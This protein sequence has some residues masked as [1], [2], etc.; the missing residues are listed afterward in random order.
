[1]Q[2][3][4]PNKK[5]WHS[6]LKTN[7]DR[8]PETQEKCQIKNIQFFFLLYSGAQYFLNTKFG[9]SNE[10]PS[11][12]NIVCGGSENDIQACRSTWTTAV[13]KGVDNVG[14]SCGN[15]VIYVLNL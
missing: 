12:D 8:L 15:Y 4:R 13:C 14:L 10:Q 1:V 11:I 3:V 5:N 6:K 9:K 7:T 2:F